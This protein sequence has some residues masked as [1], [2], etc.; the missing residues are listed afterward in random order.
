MDG[1]QT[2]DSC[3]EHN[4]VEW[5]GVKRSSHVTSAQKNNHTGLRGNG[6]RP[7][8]HFVLALNN[9]Y[10][11]M[12]IPGIWYHTHMYM[13]MYYHGYMGHFTNET[14]KRALQ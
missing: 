4:G 2:T 12:Y 8:T 14:H 3:C 10:M 7:K 5:G 9:M 6:W 13:Y 11:Y 1:W